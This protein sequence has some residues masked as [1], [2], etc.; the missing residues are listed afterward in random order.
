[1]MRRAF[2]FVPVLL[3][4]SLPI[5]SIPRAQRAEAQS[6]VSLPTIIETAKTPPEVNIDGDL[7]VGVGDFNGDGATDLL[8]NHS[9]VCTDCNLGLDRAVIVF[10][11]AVSASGAGTAPAQSILTFSRPSPFTSMSGGIFAV[12]SLPGLT[13][14]K[15]N[16]IAIIAGSDRPLLSV[17]IDAVYIV[18]GSQLA[19]LQP[20]PVNGSAFHPDV[21]LILQP[22]VVRFRIAGVGDVNGDGVKDLVFL[23]TNDGQNFKVNVLLG[24]FVS[25]QTIDLRQSGLDAAIISAAGEPL[26]RAALADVNGDGISD[27]LIGRNTVPITQ[28]AGFGEV[29]VVLGSAGLKDAAVVNL[30]DGGADAVISP[31]FKFGGLD[32][33]TVT[34]GDVNGDG[35]DDILVETAADGGEACVVFGSRSIM[36]RQV[37]LSKGQQDVTIKGFVG[38]PSQVFVNDFDGDGIADMLVA[39]AAHPLTGGHKQASAV[40]GILGS[41]GLQSGA[42]ID[43][44]LFEQD[45]TIIGADQ[46]FGLGQFK[47]DYNSDGTPDIVVGRDTLGL[48]FNDISGGLLNSSRVGIIFGGP[49]KPPSITAAD[50]R[51]HKL[52]LTGSNFTGAAKIEVNGSI[53]GD[54]ANFSPVD[55][56]LTVNGKAALLNLHSGANQIVVIRKG[57]RSN[58]FELDL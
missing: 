36:G 50:F 7:L 30:S 53:F 17:N 51:R 24:P 44:S 9:P 25:G 46:S 54:S 5:T 3:V 13:G 52:I 21:T 2:A 55:G 31:T 39:A 37:D 42:V 58:T 19:Q 34:A 20:G 38:L 45:L 10:G 49:I 40:Y 22:G 56:T 26:G 15:G 14:N 35:I 12:H 48:G 8:F 1:M 16:D 29:D 11:G 43:V 41:T 18:F 28:Q 47:L 23:T 57:S 6:A 4:L 32:P 33:D 27:I